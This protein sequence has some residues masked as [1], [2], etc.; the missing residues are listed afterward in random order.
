VERRGEGRESEGE[1]VGISDS[2]WACMAT[3]FKAGRKKPNN[4]TLIVTVTSY[5]SEILCCVTT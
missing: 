2:C 1:K 3:F 5:S 4:L